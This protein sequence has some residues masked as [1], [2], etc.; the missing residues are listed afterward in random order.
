MAKHNEQ[1]KKTARRLAREHGYEC[2]RKRPLLDLV[3]AL[4]K[5]AGI[6]PPRRCAPNSSPKGRL[7]TVVRLLSEQPIDTNNNTKTKVV[8]NKRKSDA[9]VQQFYASYAWHKAR[10][11]ILAKYGRACMVCGS[12]K[13]TNV[14]HIKPLRFNWDI[15]L[16][17]SNLQV[18]CGPCNHGKGNW[19]ETDWRPKTRP[20]LMPS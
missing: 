20:R 1:L 11:V 13:N 6:K 2:G 18:L 7:K 12:E 19:D 14:D 10:Y 8:Q 17:L 16:T 5:I 3:E 9:E 15:R 4:E